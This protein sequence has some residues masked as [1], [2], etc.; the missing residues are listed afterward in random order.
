MRFFISYTIIPFLIVSFSCLQSNAAS[1]SGYVTDSSGSPLP[2]ASVYIKNSTY[3]TSSNYKGEYYIELKAG[4][5]TLV[6]SFVG[7]KVVEKTISIRK[8]E[9]LKI[10]VQLED[11]DKL[12][13]EIEIVADKRDRAKSILAKARQHRTSYLKNIK[14]YVADT[15]VKTSLQKETFNNDSLSK[16]ERKIAKANNIIIPGAYKKES[17]HL[18][19]YVA[20][21]YYKKPGNYK[22]QILGFQDFSNKKVHKGGRRFSMS[23]GPDNA[24]SREHQDAK[25]FVRS[26][27]Y[28]FYSG[29]SKGDFSF[30]ENLLDF[31]S[32]CRQPLKSPIGINS[33]LNYKFDFIESFYEN[34]KKINK[35]RVTPRLKSEA[36]FFGNIFIQDSTWALVSAN[37]SVNKAALQMYK[38]FNIVVQYKEIEQGIYLPK[39]IKINYTIKDGKANILGNTQIK[40]T[41]YIV[42]TPLDK[43][44]FNNEIKVY[45]PKAFDRDST[46][47]N[48]YRTTALKEEELKF[49]TKADSIKAYYTSDKFLDQKD[50]LFNVIDFWT[51]LAGIG[52][53][54]HYLGL[55]MHVG[56]LLEQIVPLGVGGYR[57][58]LPFYVNKELNNQML[59]E[60]RQQ[61]DYGFKNKDL[62]GKVGVGLTYYP[63]K[64]VRTFVEVG[65]SYVLINDFASFEQI[66]SRSNYVNEKSIS[67][68]QKMELI[69]GLY[70]E[71]SAKYAKQI[72][73]QNIQLADWSKY[74]FGNLNEPMQFE[75][76]IKS[77]LKLELRYKINQKFVIKKNKKYIIGNNNPELFFTYRKGIPGIFNSE[78]NYDYLEVG[79]KMHLKLA[80]FGVSS[81]K[82]KFGGFATKKNLR[83]LE[84]NYIRG[85]DLVFFSDPTQTFQVLSSRTIFTNGAFFQANYIHHF[86]GVFL[87]KMPLNNYLKLS[88]A[89]GGGLLSVPDQAFTHAE[90]FVGIERV[91]RIKK[92]L[93]RFGIYAASAANSE[94]IGN[95]RFKFG[96]APWMS[97]AQR[98]AF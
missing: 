28:I 30:Y 63:K 29:N 98:W 93:L 38:E 19:E 51:P 92:Q 5:Y 87:N 34:G 72:S 64:F 1:V 11:T 69:N 7:C 12:L 74:L 78:V 89:A 53:K 76:Y 41:N 77:E 36:L 57:H 81:G 96:I 83:I 52:Y 54:N 3:G 16:A 97:Y 37:L 61:I 59:L 56:G 21:S 70:A 88:L 31:Y 14:N 60:T 10:D 35:I 55:E 43:T 33:G 94:S 49:I 20:K 95:F 17:I 65:N 24:Y 62:K 84:Y 26:N 44:I 73:I 4:T 58:R 40:R 32:L 71:F 22:E 90:I 47:W 85:S 66:F 42:N 48:K 45:D 25:N 18:S 79:G 13:N 2:M 67:I 15:Y 50:S 27:P 46:Y 86:D 80:R 6:Y 8:N 91:F 75:D 23:A 39:N 82:F 9:H 68:S